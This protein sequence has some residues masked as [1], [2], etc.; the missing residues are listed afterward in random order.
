MMEGV[1]CGTLNCMGHPPPPA[2]PIIWGEPGTNGQ[3]AFF[4]LIHQGACGV[5][6]LL[7]WWWLL[8]WGG[9]CCGGGGCCG[10]V[11]VVVVVVV[12]V[13]WLLWCVCGGCCGVGNHVVWWYS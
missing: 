8:W 12:V 3:H 11:V 7:W 1:W 13:G 9:C 6:W 10:G 5:G 4:Q 2:G